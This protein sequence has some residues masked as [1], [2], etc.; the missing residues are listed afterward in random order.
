MVNTVATKNRGCIVTHVLVK[1]KYFLFL[2]LNKRVYRYL[3]YF[4]FDV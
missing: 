4:P 1:G 2:I 3:V